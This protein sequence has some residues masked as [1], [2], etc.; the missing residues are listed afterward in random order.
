VTTAAGGA[1]L[2]AHGQFF[3]CPGETAEAPAGTGGGDAFLAALLVGLLQGHPPARY[4]AAACSAAQVAGAGLFA[5]PG[6]LVENQTAPVADGLP[7][8]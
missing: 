6:L 5:P 2:W 7:A 1:T 8:P 4:L 3:H